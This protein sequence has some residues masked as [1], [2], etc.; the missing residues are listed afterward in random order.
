MDAR[1]QSP[2][3]G[4][5]IAEKVAGGAFDLDALWPAHEWEGSEELLPRWIV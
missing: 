3:T 5:P 2:A 4:L 1:P